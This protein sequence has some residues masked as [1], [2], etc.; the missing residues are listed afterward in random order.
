[1]HSSF[2]PPN[3]HY[4]SYSS[5]G[6]KVFQRFWKKFISELISGLFNQ[7][8]GFLKTDPPAP[9][10]LSYILFTTRTQTVM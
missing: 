4:F 6:L 3:F 10:Q 2:I 1:M 7:L 8:Q 9:G 5:V